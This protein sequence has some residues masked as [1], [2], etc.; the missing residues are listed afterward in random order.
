MKKKRI[1][2]LVFI[3]I[4]SI[5]F[6]INLPTAAKYVTDRIKSNHATPYTDMDIVFKQLDDFLGSY[7]GIDNGRYTR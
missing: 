5:T 3:C 6:I 7:K 4:I 1:I 2:I